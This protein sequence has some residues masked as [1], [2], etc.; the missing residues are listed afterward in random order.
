MDRRRFRPP[1]SVEE[2]DDCFVV[3]DHDG[4]QLAYVYF[5]DEPG[6][7]SAANWRRD[8]AKN[9]RRAR[10]IAVNIAKFCLEKAKLCC[11]SHL[12]YESGI[13]I[14]KKVIWQ[15]A[16]RSS[17][18]AQ[19]CLNGVIANCSTQYHAVQVLRFP[20]LSLHSRVKMA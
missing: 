14:T 4:Q 6:G 19:P 8:E 2:Q 1:W 20:S 12:S 5:E 11:Q 16:G 10:R 15:T 7:D 17:H 18:G 9:C 3:R 13:T